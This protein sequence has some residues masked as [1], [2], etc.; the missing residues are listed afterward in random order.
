MTSATYQAGARAPLLA[1]CALFALAAT[2]AWSATTAAT[3]AATTTRATASDASSNVF[4]AKVSAPGDFAALDGPHDAL[5]D[6]NLGE[7]RL[8]EASVTIDHGTVRFKDPAAVVALIPDLIDPAAITA[9]L[10]GPLDS[11]AGLV[12]GQL[13]DLDC[14]VLRPP[15][16]GVI[17]DEDQLRVTVFVNPQLRKAVAEGATGFLPRPD[18]GLS[19]ASNFGL[20]LSGTGSH[21]P[22]Y[23]AQ[24]RN[25][26]ALGSARIRSN[27]ALASGFGVLVDDL[28]AEVDRP[29]QRFSAGLFW[30]PGNDFTGE[31]RI[32]GAGF[33]TQLDTRADRERLEGT[34]LFLFLQQPARVELLVDGR[35]V[36]ARYYEAG[37]NLI[38]TARLPSG[39]YNLVLRIQEGSGPI[40]EEQRF[41]V[42]SAEM[43][44]LGRPLF[45]AM[46]GLLANTR[47][48]RPVSLER[49]LYYS[50]GANVRL[51]RWLGVEGG[52]TGTS[53]KAIGQAGAYVATRLVRV[54]AIGFMSSAHDHGG[55]LQLASGDLGRVQFTL[56]L[57]R[58]ASRSGDTLLPLQDGGFGFAGRP[59]DSVDPRGG[60]YTQLTGN[61]GLQFGP[62]T[63]QVTGFYRG[64]AGTR[65]YSIG[66]SA[67]W[68]LG[69]IGGLQL[70]MLSDLQLTR[71]GMAG[72]V[73]A[74]M[75]MS[76]GAFTTV[77]S[78]GGAYGR[79]ADG[80]QRAR[81]VTNVSSQ[82][83]TQPFDDA[84][85][86]LTGGL[87]RDQ[88]E[89]SLQGSASLQSRFGTARADVIKRLGGDF[90]Y[91]LSIQSGGAARGDGVVVGGRDLTESALIATVRGRGGAFELLVDGVP[92]GRII[93]GRS[94]PIFLSPYRSYKIQLKPLSGGAIDFDPAPRTVTLYPGNVAHAVW[95]ARKLTTLFGKLVDRAGQ[96]LAGARLAEGTEEMVTADSGWFQF[97]R[98]AAK[99]LNFVR[100]DGSPCA[101][102]LPALPADKDYLSLGTVTCS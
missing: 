21:T 3:T 67:T 54:R 36:D 89:S 94:L 93:N 22:L 100:P 14:G 86:A 85:L 61:L 96:P 1:G 87:N 69:Q 26:L 81:A 101:V 78:G 75:I 57:R 13:N 70:T 8:G 27:V 79:G 53:D 59:V 99:T 35:L 74:R 92:R 33:E 60:S 88:A 40:R 31:R 64:Q 41:F 29:D 20:S 15:V 17:L 102:A 66:P 83:Q 73:G 55:L 84:Q 28:V 52:V 90:G 9:A 82:W 25:V 10:A 95:T 30:A 46:A 39:S 34:P 4:D 98:G 58:V 19:L 50:G 68:R 71:A 65:D 44:P 6:V 77:S 18:S 56:D 42:R 2:P 97:D 23:Q 43:A 51:S 16:A 49:Q 45:H 7:R 76:R 48:G 5:M 72:F 62:V 38:D 80:N 37:N 91:S 32:L 11:H 47:P 12:C 24:T 63:M